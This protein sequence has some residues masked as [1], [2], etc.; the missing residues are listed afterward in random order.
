MTRVPSSAG[1]TT[2]RRVRG[3]RAAKGLAKAGTIGLL[4]LVLSGCGQWSWNPVKWFQRPPPAGPPLVEVLNIE[5]TSANAAGERFEQSWDG[6]R[7]IV[8]VH[9]PAGIG[10]AILRP[11]GQGW[12]LRLAFRLHVS[13]LEGFEAR[14][15]QNMRI[16][17]GR[18]PLPEPALIDV[19][20]G[21]VAKDSEQLEVQWVDHYR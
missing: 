7:L 17:L 5:S 16:S 9:S 14:A 19:P 13:A 12:P 11:A 8:D 20:Y 4:A 10:K 21:V 18:E 1:S 6:A 3:G 15:A 2:L